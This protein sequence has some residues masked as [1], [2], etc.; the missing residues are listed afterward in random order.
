MAGAGAERVATTAGPRWKWKI[1]RMTR[2]VEPISST[3]T[4]KLLIRA[5]ILTPS[6]LMIVAKTTRI[7]PRMSAFLAPS[8]VL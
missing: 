4:P 6:M 7:A 2:I 1:S 3:I 8:G 5:M